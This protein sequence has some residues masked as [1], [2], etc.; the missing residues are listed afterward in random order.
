MVCSLKE[1]QPGKSIY[2]LLFEFSKEI[3][4]TCFEL[5]LLYMFKMKCIDFLKYSLKKN[6]L[7]VHELICNYD[8]TIET[9]FNSAWYEYKIVEAELYQNKEI[10]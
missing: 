6:I 9:F 2:Q 5:F 4:E 8:S 7:S 3:E 10:A 1:K